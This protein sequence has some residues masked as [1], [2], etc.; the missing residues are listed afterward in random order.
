MYVHVGTY[1]T[2][3]CVRVIL[4]VSCLFFFGQSVTRTD[5][6]ICFSTLVPPSRCAYSLDY[7]VL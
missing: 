7:T 5:K 4:C 1:P 6:E 2:T 3:R